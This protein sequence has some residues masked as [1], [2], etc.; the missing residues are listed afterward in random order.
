MGPIRRDSYEGVEQNAAFYNAH[1]HKATDLSLN[2]FWRHLYDETIKLLPLDLSTAIVD[3]GCGPGYFAKVLYEEGF[4]NYRG[5]DFSEA[6]I[7]IAR[8][9]VPEF[10][11]TVGNITKKYVPKKPEKYDIFIL[12][13]TLEHIKDDLD[14]LAAIPKGKM[15]ILSVPSAGGEGHVR[16]FKT[17]KAVS[18]RY[19]SYVDFK[20]IL[21]LSLGPA[22]KK[23][24]L[25]HGKKI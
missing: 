22:N 1:A 21:G 15:V 11:F 19:E 13:E 6:S 25:S 10:M 17:S 2:P 16:R 20:R 23:F 18:I 14:V 4:W 12:L 3:L 9:N 7:E 8:R 5:I 24:W